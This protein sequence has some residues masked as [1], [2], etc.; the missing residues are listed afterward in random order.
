MRLHAK[1][2]HWRR[3]HTICQVNVRCYDYRIM[4]TLL[5]FWESTKELVWRL[6]ANSCVSSPL[7]PPMTPI[8]LYITL[9]YE[10]CLQR[11][12]RLQNM[13]WH[14]RLW[15]LVAKADSIAFISVYYS[16]LGGAYSS[17]G[18]SNAF[19]ATKAGSLAKRQIMLA[20]WLKDMILESKC[21][22][23]YAEDLIQLQKF[24]RAKRIIRKQLEYAQKTQNDISKRDTVT[25]S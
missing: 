15:A 20:R 8:F 2:P 13:S 16:V 17:L 4:E 23:Y 24:R 14:R 25:S 10:R 22:L 5:S 3:D 19:Y 9:D 21:W 18:K 12:C 1:L 7:I 6:L 11:A